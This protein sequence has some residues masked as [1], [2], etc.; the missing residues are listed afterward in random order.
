MSNHT[1]SITWQC[2]AGEDFLARRYS[3]AHTWTFDGGATVPA[4]SSPSVVP[5]PY[6]DAAGVDPEEAYV[7]SVAS[8]HMLWYLGLA[9][10][11]GF[12]V[13]QY[14][15]TATGTLTKDVNGKEWI[16]A[17][18]LAPAVK[19]GAGSSPSAAEEEGLHHAAHE[20]CF[21]ANSVRTVIT[22]CPS[23]F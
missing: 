9:A 4:S 1:A 2:R 11:Q 13:T 16:S 5:L 23:K 20:A 17:V 15:D 21:I 19:Y 7:A 8:C 6:S 10:Q 3:R 18:S 12:T 22:I 14:T